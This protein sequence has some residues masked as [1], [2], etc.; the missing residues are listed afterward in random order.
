STAQRVKVEEKP[1]VRK[2]GGVY[3][4]PKYI[5]DYIVDNTVGKI[6]RNEDE[7]IPS[8]SVRHPRTREADMQSIGDPEGNKNPLLESDVIPAKAG[9]QDKRG[10][11]KPQEI[12]KLRF[13]DIACG[14]GSFLIGVFEVLLKYHTEYY[15]LH[16]AEA[17][18]DGCIFKDGVP[19]LSIKQ[20]QKILLNNIYG[21]DLDNQA[22]E[23]TQLSLALKMLED[24]TLATANEMQAL[25]HE[26]ILPDLSKNIVCGNSLIGTDIIYEESSSGLFEKKRRITSEE[27]RQLNPMDFEKRF[28]EIMK[29]GGFDAIVGNPPYVRQEQ[30][31]NIKEYLIN[32]YVVFLGM[33]DLYS[34]FIERG[35]KLLNETGK[36]G[37]IVANKWMRA[38]YGVNLRKFLLRDSLKQIIDFGDFPVLIKI[39]GRNFQ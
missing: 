23:V 34:Y 9:T 20:K 25:F 21:V 35:I 28:P 5:V 12:S 37:Y 10:G 14:S 4:T 24:E 17:K 27:E 22:V 38:N 31:G 3:Y 19:I 39:T 16:D 32:H 11:L 29:N 6:I 13:A 2:T 7:K 18:K 1:E 26:K 33:A 15:Q 36:F 30:L 8:S